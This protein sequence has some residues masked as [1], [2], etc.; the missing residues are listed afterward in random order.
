MCYLP[1]QNNERKKGMKKILF[2]IG[3]ALVFGSILACDIETIAFGQAIKQCMV[4]LPL[5]AIGVL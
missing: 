4:G 2:I 1:N 3:A 5:M